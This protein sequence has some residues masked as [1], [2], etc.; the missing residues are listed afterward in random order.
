MNINLDSI[1][2]A[3]ITRD[4]GGPIVLM[5]SLLLFCSACIDILPGS[6]TPHPPAT[7]LPAATPRPPA[8]ALPAATAI[9][10]AP[11][12]HCPTIDFDKEYDQAPVDFLDLEPDLE[13]K[14]I[15]AAKRAINNP[16]ILIPYGEIYGLRATRS[17]TPS[18]S[19]SEL[20]IERS[21]GS[22]YYR[23]LTV[24]YRYTDG[25]VEY[26]SD[27]SASQVEV[28]VLEYPGHG[29]EVEQAFIPRPNRGYY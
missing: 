29:C 23:R 27:D 25:S 19:E 22:W 20:A 5:S 3:F 2:K 18:I 13:R 17:Y 21:D 9:V 26:S 28:Y 12:H 15:E 6:A 14:I 7:A 4:C 8:T 10:E 11:P 24:W 16:N 1:A